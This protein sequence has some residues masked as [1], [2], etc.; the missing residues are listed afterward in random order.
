MRCARELP[1]VQRR[2][3]RRL[4]RIRSACRPGLVGTE[5]D[6][7]TAFAVIEAHTMWASFCRAYYLSCCF[8]ARDA[9]GIKVLPSGSRF[10]TEEAALTPAIYLVKPD[11]VGK[12]PPWAP[13]DEPAW[14][15][16][17]QF[18]R[19]MSNVGATSASTV[20]AAL[21]YSPRSLQTL[22][23]IRNFYAHRSL[24]SATKV[25][26]IYSQYVLEPAPVHSR[27]RRHRENHPTKF[28]NSYARSRPQTI[29]GDLLD[30][31]RITIE[32]MV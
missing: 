25:R 21:A 28:L 26:R 20:V 24:T 18:R 11:L 1:V 14:F 13:R 31:L 6:R 23:T 9:Q 22:T 2:A 19:V 7:T 4:E 5:L 10:A 3:L 16:A 30:D 15:D 12:S 27:S 29:L 17:G 32:M 8:S